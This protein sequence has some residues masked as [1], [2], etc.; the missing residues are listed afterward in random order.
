MPVLCYLLGLVLLLVA[1]RDEAVRVDALV[2][3]SCLV[4]WRGPL[5]GQERLNILDLTREGAV[6][7]GLSLRR[8]AARGHPF[9]VLLLLH[10]DTQQCM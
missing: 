1:R 7:Q 3:R 8:Q 2:A 9:A 10:R 6:S 5:H 4:S